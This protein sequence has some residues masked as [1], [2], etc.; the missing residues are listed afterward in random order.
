M[1]IL[2]GKKKKKLPTYLPYFSV[3]RYANTTT[4]KIWPKIHASIFFAK[5]S[6]T[7]QPRGS[8][9]VYVAIRC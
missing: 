7:W 8:Y 5:W 3:A 9:R 6:G 2:L 4:K 1:G